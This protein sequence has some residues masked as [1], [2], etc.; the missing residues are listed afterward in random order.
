MT[1]DDQ[2]ELSLSHY[3]ESLL[4]LPSYIVESFYCTIFPFHPSKGPQF[5]LTM[6]S[7]IQF[8]LPS[9]SIP[10]P[11]IPILSPHLTYKIY[12]IFLSQGNTVSSQDH[13][14]P[15]NICGFM[16]YRL[17]IIYIHIYLVYQSTRQP[18]LV[19]LGPKKSDFIQN[20]KH[21]ILWWLISVTWVKYI[22][23][24]TSNMWQKHAF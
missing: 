23:M 2:L 13:L 15:P 3:L 11:L 10:D 12:S 19:R 14:S 8:H 6:L 18:E 5:C 7:L 24:K 20:I 1:K 4:G 22:I 21:F 17:F 9:S 16:D